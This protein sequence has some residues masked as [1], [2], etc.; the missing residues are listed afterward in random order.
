MP[1]FKFKNIKISAVSTAVPTQ[2]ITVDSFA[3]Q[4]G[5]DYVQKFQESTGIHQ[6]HKTK[7]HQTASDLCFAAAENIF[8][9]K[10]RSDPSGKE[11]PRAEV[12]RPL[13]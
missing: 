6:F 11:R 12:G 3:E 13:T 10:E 8:S 7:E 1:Y 4:F 9:K 2:I 5:E